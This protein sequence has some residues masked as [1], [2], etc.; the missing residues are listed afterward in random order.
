VFVSKELSA[1]MAV[2]EQAGDILMSRFGKALAIRYKDRINLV[3]R[4]DRTSE[5]VIV[6][7]L[8]KSYPAYGI[9]AE[10]GT[11]I[12]GD[13]RW[14]IDPLDGTTNYVH[15][16]PV[17]CVSIA[18]EKEGRIVLGV[19]Y[20]PTR[21]EMFTAQQGKGAFLNRRR[22]RVSGTRDIH[23]AFLVTGF[24]YDVQ[25]SKDN[26][27]DHFAAF[28][29]KAQAVRRDGSAALN[30]AYLACGRFDG[31]WE[32]KLHPWDTAAGS[33]LV[34][35]AGGKTTDFRGG[36][37]SIYGHETLATNGLI[38]KTM[39]KILALNLHTE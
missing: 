27:L 21:K 15:G 24:A 31:F 5:R 33:L 36:P 26:N 10:E 22:I 28:I 38:H 3:T 4:A 34:A 23:R 32:L 2:A 13:T 37:F 17:F 18:L 39:Q 14:L 35:E 20:D 12:Q 25:T 6:Q 8:Q 11:G 16:Y 1:A 7:R 29:R 19:I 30:L 9:L